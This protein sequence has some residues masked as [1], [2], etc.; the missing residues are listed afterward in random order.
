MQADIDA[1]CSFWFVQLCCCVVLCGVQ[2]VPDAGADSI[3]FLNASRR[4]RMGT[5]TITESACR[6]SCSVYRGWSSLH[7]STPAL[8]SSLILPSS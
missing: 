5:S 6:V 1:L 3:F 7:F 2:A 4:Y 8:S